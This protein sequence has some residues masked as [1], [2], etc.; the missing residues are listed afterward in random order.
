MKPGG[1]FFLPSEYETLGGFPK[2]ICVIKK[3]EN[4]P[5]NPREMGVEAP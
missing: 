4:S 5:S 1:M 2:D 3:K